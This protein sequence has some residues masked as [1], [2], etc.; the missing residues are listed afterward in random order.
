MYK[1]GNGRYMGGGGTI[2]IYIYM[3]V[4]VYVLQFGKNMVSNMQLTVTEYDI[5]ECTVSCYNI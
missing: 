1:K 3:C 5:L 4:C 2:Y